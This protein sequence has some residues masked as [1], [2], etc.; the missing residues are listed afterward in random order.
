MYD[1]ISLVLWLTLAA[2]SGGSFEPTPPNGQ[3][4]QIVTAG[5][6][7][8]SRENSILS[9]DCA[10]ARQTLE[11]AI[12]ER[13]EATLRLGL[14]KSAP[15]FTREIVQAVKNA[16]YQ[17]FVPDL[18]EMLEEL[19]VPVSEDQRLTGEKRELEKAIVSALMH[20]TGLR[21]DATEDLSAEDAQK[22]VA[23]SRRWYAAN[24]SEIQKS[25]KAEMLDRQQ[26]TSILSSNFRVARWAFDK[27]VAEKDTATLRLGLQKNSL[28]LRLLIV[29]AIK[30]FDD[31]S[32]VPDL[33]QT[34]EENQSMMS[35][36]SETQMA[37]QELRKEIIDAL[38]HLTG[39]QFSYLTDESFVSCFSECP[40]K[41]IQKVLQES[42]EWWTVNKKDFENTETK[43][44]QP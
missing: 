9:S 21:F 35:G 8:A 27:A 13:D 24:E 1:V 39:L 18:T 3:N 11:K 10:V 40:S 30:Q 44:K 25:Y 15:A 38:K 33:I 26:T 16:Y 6:P 12:V 4:R 32:F 42:R 7:A 34:L 36:G 22:T 29:K 23:E 43:S 5:T 37:Q 2:G 19:R 17:T 20:L 41:D 31:R 14:K 28:T